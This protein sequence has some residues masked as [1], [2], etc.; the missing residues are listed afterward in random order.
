MPRGV[1]TVIWNGFLEIVKPSLCLSFSGSLHC[2]QQTRGEERHC[3]FSCF[4]RSDPRPG[5]GEAHDLRQAGEQEALLVLV[6]RHGQGA[7]GGGGR[8]WLRGRRGSR[9]GVSFGKTNQAFAGKQGIVV[10]FQVP[11][12]F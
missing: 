4:L 1:P 6:G 10:G 8:L 9:I 5:A 12:A 11:A 7:R 2:T 3:V